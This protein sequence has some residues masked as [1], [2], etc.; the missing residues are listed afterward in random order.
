MTA[1][2]DRSGEAGETPLGGSTEGESAVTAEGGQAPNKAQDR[3]MSGEQPPSMREKIARALAADAFQRQASDAEKRRG[4]SVFLEGWWK[5]YLDTADAVLD[6]LME[7]T[8][9]MIGV[10]EGEIFD[11][12]AMWQ[13]MISAAKNEGQR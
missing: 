3:A 12:V 13:A 7:P 8:P 11:S 9:A 10:G 4:P 2:A 5:H 6:A 1:P